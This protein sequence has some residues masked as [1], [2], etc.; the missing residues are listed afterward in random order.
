MKIIQNSQSAKDVLKLFASY[1]QTKGTLS[2]K[3]EPVV[4]MKIVLEGHAQIFSVFLGKCYYLSL[5]LSSNL[6]PILLAKHILGMIG[7][8]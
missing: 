2:T 8:Q 7:I 3:N 1:T 6:F 4:L 5:L